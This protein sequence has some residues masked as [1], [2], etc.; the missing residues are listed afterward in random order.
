MLPTWQ[1]LNLVKSIILFK[2]FLVN[3]DIYLIFTAVQSTQGIKADKTLDSRQENW[4]KEFSA[5]AKEKSWSPV[6]PL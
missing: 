6:Q 2:A 4:G 3:I 5:K 1:W